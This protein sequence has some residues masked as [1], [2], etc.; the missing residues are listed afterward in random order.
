MYY[1]TYAT[2]ILVAVAAYLAS[3][4]V[5]PASA[6]FIPEALSGIAVL[7]VALA[8]IQQRFRFIAPKYWLIFAGLLVV[9]LC[10][11]LSN[12]VASGPIVAG[13]RY[14]LRALP[15]FFLPAIYDFKDWQLRRLFQ[16]LMLISILQCPL[17]V[18]QRFFLEATGHE[19]GDDVY[20]TLMLSGTLSLFLI[21]V[22]S[23]ATAL[24]M[25]ERLSFRSYLAL[26]LVLLIPMSINE[27]KITVLL[28]PLA[29]LMTILLASPRGKRLQRTAIGLGVLAMGACIFVPI[30]N[31]YNLHHQSDSFTLQEYFSNK[32]GMLTNYLSTGARVG[33]TQEAGRLDDL[34]VP[35]Q[36]L[37][38]DPVK[39]AFGVGLGN[40]SKSSLG[41][42]FSGVYYPIYWRYETSSGTFLLETGVFGLALILLLHWQIAR[43]ALAI[44]RADSSIVD[45]MA[46]AWPA[47]VIV[48]TAGLFYIPIHLSEAASYAFFFFSG[49]IA[50]R[51]VRVAATVRTATIPT[52]NRAADARQLV[53]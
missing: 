52:R 32:N 20:G 25:R 50:A 22:L 43:D 15:F 42:A 6:K 14:Y 45:S 38:R 13:T 12:H 19:S 35:L 47:A 29:L 2:F 24:L 40:A 26:F 48:M 17:A 16:L 1:F 8:G 9:I 7:Y 33:T 49:L 41:P 53:A 4:N 5:V 30:Y 21:C 23:V 34:I 44:R 36:E 10:G 51:R 46:H 37:S 39:F 3:I 11:I 27:T 18:H 28:L 31:Y